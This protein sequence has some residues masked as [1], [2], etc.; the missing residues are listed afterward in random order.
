MTRGASLCFSSRSSR[1]REP[2]RTACWP[3]AALAISAC[4]TTNPPTEGGQ[5]GSPAMPPDGRP[6]AP[7]HQSPIEFRPPSDRAPGSGEAP[8]YPS[9]RGQPRVRID[10][11]QSALYVA[12]G[13][14]GLVVFDRRDEAEP[15]LVGGY[16]LPGA[17]QWLAVTGDRLTVIAAESASSD[18]FEAAAPTTTVFTFDVGNDALHPKLLSSNVVD[19]AFVEARAEAERVIL[20]TQ[21]REGLQC[22][23]RDGWVD[24]WQPPQ[25]MVVTE[26][27]IAEAGAAVVER[28]ELA[29]DGYLGAEGSFVITRGW[30]GGGAQDA[31]IWV[32]DFAE[33]GELQVSDEI[34][35]EDQVAS[36]P[37]RFEGGVLEFV[38]A[39]QGETVFNRVTLDDG[40]VQQRS[41]VALPPEVGDYDG[42]G[43]DIAGRF[44]VLS[45]EAGAFIVDVA[46]EGGPVVTGQLPADWREVVLAGEQWI[47]LGDEVA[48]LMTIDDDGQPQLGQTV[49]TPYLGRRAPTRYVG[50]ERRLY[51]PYIA[52]GAAE[53][54]HVGALGLLD[55]GELVW[56]PGTALLGDPQVIDFSGGASSLEMFT[57]GG[58]V[59]TVTH[60]FSDGAYFDT[61][62][63][64]FDVERDETSLPL[65]LG[66]L[67]VDVA[68]LSDT[69]VRLLRTPTGRALKLVAD[70]T[71]TRLDL[72]YRTDRLLAMDQG[73]L[74][75]SFH[76]DNP[77]YRGD[78][79]SSEE[80]DD[81]RPC[82]KAGTPAVSYVSLEGD[83][84]L[85]FELELPV[86][87]V[88][89]P[90]DTTLTWE[91][92]E[93]VVSG[94]Q[95]GLLQRRGWRCLSVERCDAMGIAYEM[96]SAGG[97]PMCDEESQ[98][99]E[100]MQEAVRVRGYR[101]DQWYYPLDVDAGRFEPPFQVGAATGNSYLTKEGLHSDDGVVF[102]EF[103]D[104]GRSDQ[105]V[106]SGLF[107]LVTTTPS[108]DDASVQ[109][110]TVQGFPMHADDDIV[111]TVE[112]RGGD[113]EQ[114]VAADVDVH[115]LELFE[116]TAYLT[117]TLSI[118]H[119]HGG[120]VWTGSRGYV[121]LYGDDRCVENESELVAVELD[122]GRLSELGRLELE[123]TGW[124][125][126]GASRQRVVLVREADRQARY[127]V[128]SVGDD[129]LEMLE[130]AVL[131]M[132][133][134]VAVDGDVVV[135]GARADRSAVES[136]RE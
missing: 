65:S 21:T 60:P 130:H 54:P 122:G 101:D 30:A 25:S 75:Y 52:R 112:P 88:E 69:E 135:L 133:L 22:L 96:D 37:V 49:A 41:V 5:T 15:V 134:P 129:G 63:E 114:G 81:E 83:P 125:L 72:Q 31:A 53:T 95:V 87:E 23:P 82:T 100:Q 42:V 34:A 48:A 132:A 6:I 59:Y 43:G 47:A 103:T 55:G 14:R 2:W 136:T 18:D 90:D 118:G 1:V 64:R 13:A 126:V 84:E 121:L 39:R 106:K 123:G 120:H 71:T 36:S 86:P 33:A 29:G 7:D 73:L 107:E 10:A 104:L 80:R 27:S 24:Y 9:R 109:R 68:H 74:A 19:G 76:Y 62:L 16:G 91:W 66:D 108:N 8:R 115:L 78:Y 116:G 99:G 111:V 46:V 38:S 70:G 105:S 117:Q 97:T 20:L 40:A 102:F 98:C 124:R 4:A 26:L 77:C 11:R 128:V 3:L 51:V 119:G 44:A 32:V 50:S 56:V 110:T 85:V 67:P 79:P 61:L 57:D 94:S 89:L 58:A 12:D 92:N 35:V 28:R 131:P 127:L 17:A 113:L 93:L 45:S